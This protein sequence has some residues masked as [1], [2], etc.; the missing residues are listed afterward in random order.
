LP[1]WQDATVFSEQERAALRLTD[2]MTRDI[3]V[4]RETIHAVREYLDERQTVELVATVAA[5][6]MVSRFLEALQI[7]ADDERI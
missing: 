6:N 2:T 7:R 3:H 5:Y 4:A 1:N